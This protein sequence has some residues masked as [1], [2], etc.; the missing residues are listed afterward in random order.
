MRAIRFYC[1]AVVIAGF[2]SVRPACGGILGFSTAE[3]N[4]TD[5]KEARKKCSW[6]DPARIQVESKGL[7]WGSSADEGSRDFWLQTVEPLALGESWRPPISGNVRVTIDHVG[8]AGI[9]YVRHSPDAKHWSDWQVVPVAVRRKDE[10]GQV[11]QGEIRLPYREQ[12][13]YRELLQA[14]SRREDV[15]WASDEEAFVTELVV[16]DPEYFQRQKPFIGYVQFL[17]ETQLHGGERIAGIKAEVS[18]AIG[19]V[20]AIPKNPDVN[21]ARSGPWRFKAE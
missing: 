2:A 5:S 9:L 1:L 4:L 8:T 21:K 10:T 13:P 15:P 12:G 11:F 18:W 20:H 17:Y 16:K 3:V 19:G 6:S 7:G 14:Y